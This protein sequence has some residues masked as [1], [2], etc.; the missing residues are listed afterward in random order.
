MLTFDV[1]RE[2]L[3]TKKTRWAAN[4]VTGVYA[5]IQSKGR[6]KEDVFKCWLEK[7]GKEPLSLGTYYQFHLATEA[8]DKHHIHYDKEE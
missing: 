2:N 8:C 3:T 1:E 7:K 6:N 4:G 5:I